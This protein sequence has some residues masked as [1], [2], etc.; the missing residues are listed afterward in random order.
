MRH[1][2]KYHCD[3][4]NHCLETVIFK[5][6]RFEVFITSIL[7]KSTLRRYHIKCRVDAE[8]LL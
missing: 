6:Q 2:A 3:C 8:G 5:L 1:C 7:I 4:L